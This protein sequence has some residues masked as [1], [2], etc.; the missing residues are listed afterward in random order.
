MLDIPCVILIFPVM[1]SKEVYIV[2]ASLYLDAL[3]FQ[4]VAGF[5]DSVVIRCH[6]LSTSGMFARLL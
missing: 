5:Q 1:L 2:L 4:E 6:V 3:C